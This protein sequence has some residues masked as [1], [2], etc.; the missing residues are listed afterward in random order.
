MWVCNLKNELIYFGVTGL[1]DKMHTIAY[2]IRVPSV[3]F[4]F[5]YP[6]KSRVARAIMLTA[7]CTI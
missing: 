6:R 4:A 7:W 5:K 2:L 1:H 3:A